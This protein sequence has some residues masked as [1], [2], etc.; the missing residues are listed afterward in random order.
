MPALR[1]NSGTATASLGTAIV[2]R[3]L[4]RVSEGV[5]GVHDVSNYII[6]LRQGSA[7]RVNAPLIFDVLR[8]N[9]PAFA[10]IVLEPVI[11]RGFDDLQS[12]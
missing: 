7:L 10:A 12:W 8:P 5:Q 3:L 6:S 11:H 9:C 4:S 2:L 1:V